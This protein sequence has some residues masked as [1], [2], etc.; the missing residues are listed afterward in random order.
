[1][2]REIQYVGVSGL[3][4]Y[5]R[6]F[7]P[8]DGY[9]WN[10]SGTPAFEAAV[11]GNVANYVIS[12]TEDALGVYV[13]TMPSGITVAG[14]YSYVVYRG[15]GAA[16]DPILPGGQGGYVP[17]SGSALTNHLV[18]V[19]QWLG[20]TI[21]APNVTG[22][23]LTDV[24]YILGT[25]SAGA[26]GYFGPD[27]GHINAASSTVNLSGTTIST[28]SGAV[29]SV[30]GAVGSVTG[31]V[32]SVTGNVGG[33]VTGDVQGK[34][35][36]GGASSITGTGVQA[37]LASGQVVASVSGSVG[38]VT[39]AVGSVTGNVGGNLI[40]NVNGNV[41]GNVSG[42][43]GSVT[44]AVGSVTGAVGSV[45][46]NVG[47]NV[48]GSVASVTGAV[49][50]VTGNV[51][52]DVAGK[53]LGGGSSS[54]TGAGCRADQVTG[55]VG[56]VTGAVG[57]VTGAVGSV[58][59]NVGGNVTGSVG[60]V[61]GNV[62]GSVASVVGA[63]GSVTGAVGSVTG[64]IGGNLTG[65]IGGYAS[66][67]SPATLVLDAVQASHNTAGTIGYDIG[68]S[69][70]GGGGGL[71]TGQAAQLAAV[72]GTSAEL[73]TF[74]EPDSGSN[75]RFSAA[76]LQKAPTGTSLIPSPPVSASFAF[77][78]AGLNEIMLLLF[79]NASWAGLGDSTGVV[80]SASAGNLY[81]S[82]HNADPGT[83]GNQ[84]THETAYTGYARLAVVRSGSGWNVV[85]DTTKNAADLLWPTCT[86]GSDTITYMGIGTAASGTGLL[87]CRC[88]LNTPLGVTTNVIP[89]LLANALT[90]QGP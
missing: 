63:V 79:N 26:A 82:L 54:I 20:G 25:L 87:L 90:L 83:G 75:Y 39:G 61:A 1:M 38:S 27:W 48:V 18:N 80:G 36:G 15:S 21:P 29:G 32:G 86:G 52:G 17:W 74:I 16:S 10:T 58:T 73:Q 7:R 34:V 64:G 24:K 47:G 45:T 77:T 5:A 59:G 68:L 44:G 76:G 33:S 46:G 85:G 56:S 78:V 4:I 12:L 3:T 72:A 57:S 62:S 49:G 53:L 40:G 37:S 35:L 9:V 19:Q 66:G 42:T 22:V 13:A 2:A 8:T 88:Q 6:I 30:T 43:V 11:A 50:S 55:S 84:S 41:A 65:T 23:P 28:V 31:A 89:R 14:N 81:L 69:G 51:G 60:S 67:Q 71:T 70:S